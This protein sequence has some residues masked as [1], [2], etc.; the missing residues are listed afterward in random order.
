[1]TFGGG[2]TFPR[3]IFC[4]VANDI[5]LQ[6]KEIKFKLSFMSISHIFHLLACFISTCFI[7]FIIFMDKFVIS[8]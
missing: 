8:Y 6:T 4:V 1:M 3:I 2:K 5:Q 7:S